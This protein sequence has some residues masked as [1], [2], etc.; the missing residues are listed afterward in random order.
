MASIQPWLV[1]HRLLVRLGLTAV[2]TLLGLWL[3]DKLVGAALHTQERHLLR[4][5]PNLS[6]RHRSTE[7]DYVFRSNS[8]GLR[9]PEISVERPPGTLRVAVLG[10]SF[11]AGYGVRDQDTLTHRLAELLDINEATRAVQVI[12]LG[13]VGASTVRE[14]DVYQLRGRKYRPDVVVLMYCLHNDLAEILGEQTREESR[15]WRPAGMT[16]RIACDLFPNLYFELAI[17]KQSQETKRRLGPRSESEL[18]QA[19]SAQTLQS[20]GNIDNARARYHNIPQTIRDSLE[21]G[22]FN[23]WQVFMACYDP[24][25]IRRALYPTGEFLTQAWQR[26]E[27][28]LDLL[29]A[30]ARADGAKLVLAVIPAA[31]Q[32]DPSA[33]QFAQSLGYDVATDWLTE[34]S[35]TQ[36]LLARW[37][38]QNHVDYLDLSDEFRRSSE[39]LYYPQDGHFNSAGQAKAA[40]QL[41]QFLIT[42]GL[43]GN[44]PSTER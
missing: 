24:Q 30:T 15:A 18:L 39:P 31:V 34:N 9:G 35:D 23:D 6:Y 4:L 8:Q 10:D 25:R 33:N 16:R 12:N 11:V 17:W 19:L 20:G 27:H 44:P 3:A 42:K 32:V 22:T 38:E 43:L 41:A 13:R 21:Q 1:R 26:T 5:P 40:K 37:A 14:L 28:Y 7:F 36:E 29:D 2:S